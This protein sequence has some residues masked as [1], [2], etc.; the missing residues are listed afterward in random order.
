M[1]ERKDIIVIQVIHPGK[2]LARN[3]THGS[4]NFTSWYRNMNH[5]LNDIHNSALNHYKPCENEICAALRAEDNL[6]HRVKITAVIQ[7][8]QEFIFKC[9]MIDEG[10][11][12]T[13]SLWRLR[14]LPLDFF[15]YPA[16]VSECRL[17]GVQPVTMQIE[18]RHDGLQAIN[19]PSQEWDHAAI[20]YMN[21]LIEASS[22]CQAEVVEQ[23]EDSVLHLRLYLH[24]SQ[25]YICFN[26]DLVR[27]GYA[28]HS[29]EVKSV[30]TDLPPLLSECQNLTASPDSIHTLQHAGDNNEISSSIPHKDSDILSH[31]ETHLKISPPSKHCDHCHLPGSCQLSALN[32]GRH[33]PI[34]SELGQIT[35]PSVGRGLNRL[36]VDQPLVKPGHDYHQSLASS[37]H[38]TSQ[39]AEKFSPSSPENCQNKSELSGIADL[40][41]MRQGARPK[42]SNSSI[43]SD[44]Y[45]DQNVMKEIKEIKFARSSLFDIGASFSNVKERRDDIVRQVKRSGLLNSVNSS[46]KSKVSEM[47]FTNYTVMKNDADLE[48]AKKIQHFVWPAVVGCRHVVGVCPSKDDRCLS[49]LPGLLSFLLDV[50]MYN[51]LPKGKGPLALILV[52]SWKR[53]RQ[54]DDLAEMFTSSFPK[55]VKPV[56]KIVLYAGG[57]EENENVQGE[58]LK[59]C[60]LLIST[61]KS[62]LHMLD[63][64][65]T[66]FKR[67]CHVIL[68]DSEILSTKF[69]SEVDDLMQRYKLVF[70][71][72]KKQ[73]GVPMQIMIFANHWNEGVNMFYR[74]YNREPVIVFSSRL[75]AAIYGDVKQ[76]VTMSLSGKMLVT[77]CNVIDSLFTS[78]DRLVTFTSERSEAVELWKASKSRGAYCLLIHEDLTEDEIS[79]AREQ[80]LRSCHTKQF[81]VMICTDQ[82][83]QQLAITNV[84]HYGLP[85][86]KTKFGNR[87]ACM[88]DYFRNRPSL[89]EPELQPISHVILN[90][91]LPDKA[92][93]LYEILQ[94]S[95]SERNDKFEQYI[96]GYLS[97]L[98]KD[99]KKQLCPFIKSFAKCINRHSCLFRHILLPDE[100]SKSGV[101]SHNTLPSSGDVKIRVIRVKNA[102]R[103]YCH[104]ME[105]W[106]YADRERT[107]LRLQYQK[108]IM[109]MLTYYSQERNHA[110]FIPSKLSDELCTFQDKENNYHRARVTEI[111][112]EFKSY[113]PHHYK[114]WLVDLGIEESATLEQLKKLPPELA[115]VPFQAVEVILCNLRPMDDEYE[116]TDKADM[117][118]D[119]LIHEKL[120]V[121][122][123]ALS[124]GSTLWLSPLVH[125][126]Q[127]DGIGAV[128]D[129]NIRHELI[130]RHYARPHPDHI[131]SL[132][133]M[134]RGRVSIPEHLLEKYFDF[135][136]N[137]ELKQEI[138]P[139]NL[140]FI[141]V[142]TAFVDSPSLFYLHRWEAYQLLAELED[143]IQE[144]MCKW[145]DDDLLSGK[146]MFHLDVGSVCLVQS[147]DDKWYRCEVVTKCDDDRWAVF[148]LDYGDTETVPRDSLRPLP[149]KFSRLPCQA[150]K[151]ELAYVKPN[152]E[153]WS[154]SARDLICDLSYFVNEGN[155]KLFAKVVDKCAPGP[156]MK[157]K[158]TVDIYFTREPMVRFSEEMVRHHHAVCTDQ[159]VNIKPIFEKP[160]N[161]NENSFCDILDNIPLLCAKVYWCQG[162]SS[163][164]A[165]EL[166]NIMSYRNDGWDTALEQSPALCAVISSVGYISDVEAHGRILSSLTACCR[167]SDR[168]CEMV[169]L[170]KLS[171]RLIY[172]LEQA[173]RPH[174]QCQAAETLASLATVDSFCTHI[175][176][177][178]CL[179][180][181][182]SLF[183]NIS[184]S[185][186][187]NLKT[188]KSLCTCVSQIIEK[189]D[190]SLCEE[191][192][193]SDLVQQVCLNLS[194]SEPES[195]QEPWLQLLAA[196]STCSQ[197]HPVIVRAVHL[198]TLVSLLTKASSVKCIYYNV[199]VLQ[200]LVLANRK[201]KTELQN[202][203]LFIILD[204]L[205]NKHIQS[206]ALELCQE[207]WREMNLHLP[208]PEALSG[209]PVQKCSLDQK[210]VVVPEVRWSQTSS[211]II[212][213]FVVKH[214][215]PHHFTITEDRI[216]CR[217]ETADTLYALDW[218][219]YDQV[220]PK[221]S[222]I[223][224]QESITYIKV[225]KK[226]AGQWARLLRQKLKPPTLS[227]DFDR[228][229]CSDED[230]DDP[231]SFSLTRL[232]EPY[233]MRDTQSNVQQFPRLPPSDSESDTESSAEYGSFSDSDHEFEHHPTE[234]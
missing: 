61:P 42:H 59:G 198:D 36:L 39:S 10:S 226:I 126:V 116:W 2:F 47:L 211:S 92:L 166:E 230:S 68:E 41:Y 163:E 182:L 24:T 155:K 71:E 13:S 180:E 55:H 193:T 214:A 133:D 168:I 66:S 75:E 48:S 130:E 94:R 50:E 110:P 185:D 100:D 227:V 83:Y 190:E 132:Y 156:D 183:F 30:S 109:N 4:E 177:N 192:L 53:A 160:E 45:S 161:Q 129:V 178:R 186:E 120:L 150:I 9:F 142:S 173:S 103:Y 56:R 115:A 207:L 63:E 76:I 97:T 14:K 51:E 201:Y 7:K 95:V 29:L 104:L 144:A 167:D 188:L 145:T 27:K 35:V 229:I 224:S 175:L 143:Q 106:S 228:L 112:T 37:T 159:S 1:G 196:M 122:H 216:S 203:D 78:S 208:K 127:M 179:L 74:K 72:R 90:E 15:D 26:D 12:F 82:C 70:K 212:L 80:W 85:D 38:D 191:L 119:E 234:D 98:E 107:D 141:P 232:R 23:D 187:V 174:I 204:R 138:L 52:P 101:L 213:K 44:R 220:V 181:T 172:C 194:C 25:G 79:E 17:W 146:E 121:G 171:D 11:E 89:K 5:R 165:I 46:T 43:L 16:L 209:I 65:F 225:A 206:P 219:L 128:S 140:E 19:R 148:I 189:E 135:S 157:Q 139:E 233:S 123:I 184:P 218:E 49:Y 200:H 102:T 88:L 33:S 154:T 84:L 34:A 64:D 197:S 117:F 114:L 149:R 67:L 3:L 21:Q 96:Q 8:A 54:I 87:L 222:K 28:C 77:F 124:L 62:L 162:D 105:H 217:S 20:Q 93:S 6:W 223:H 108:L 131:K 231:D 118:V 199:S 22:G 158:Y 86:S 113:S 134:F 91:K 169:I 202:R 170:E 18:I 210:V 111:V 31:H 73:Q 136:L 57:T 40:T 205:I 176:D 81:L 137:I 164:G 151:C 152:G 32:S 215:E 99:P 153:T 58:L 221:R 195:L 69:P 147:S 125:Q 60:D